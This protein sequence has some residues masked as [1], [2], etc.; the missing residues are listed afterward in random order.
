MTFEITLFPA[1]H[2]T[3]AAPLAAHWVRT[4]QKALREGEAVKLPRL[5]WV[6]QKSLS[7][8]QQE[9]RKNSP[10]K[11]ND[12]DDWVKISFSARVCARPPLPFWHLDCLRAPFLTLQMTRSWVRA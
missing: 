4:A 11:G 7:D 5:V 3:C 8:S 6:E 10:L 9:L 2:T 12:L 1:I